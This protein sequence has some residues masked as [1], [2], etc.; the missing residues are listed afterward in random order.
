MGEIEVVMRIGY[1]H[2]PIY[3]HV[4]VSAH[5]KKNV[6]IYLACNYSCVIRSSPDS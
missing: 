6:S 2:L 4:S 5:A 1:N 3:T